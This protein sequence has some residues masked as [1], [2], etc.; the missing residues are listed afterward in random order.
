L[1]Q[2]YGTTSLDLA[3]CGS[4]TSFSVLHVALF[5]QRNNK[6]KFDSKSS[7]VASARTTQCNMHSSMQS[8][9][10]HHKSYGTSWYRGGC[11]GRLWQQVYYRL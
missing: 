9:S 11:A 3:G 8:S 5:Y 10:C 6:F 1:G 2:L 4:A 7:V